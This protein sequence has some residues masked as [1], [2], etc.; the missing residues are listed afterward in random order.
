[1][2]E[3]QQHKKFVILNEI[4]GFAYAAVLLRLHHHLIV[5]LLHILETLFPPHVFHEVTLDHL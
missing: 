5:K 4:I 1:M 3:L 2:S